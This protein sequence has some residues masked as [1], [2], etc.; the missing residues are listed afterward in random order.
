VRFVASAG[1]A[2]GVKTR[3][4]R[5]GLNAKSV[6]NREEAKTRAEA[7]RPIFVE[8]AGKPANAIAAELNKRAVAT[9]R[10]GRWHAETVLRVQRRLE[11]AS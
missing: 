2:E 5:G 9:P 4:V 1:G 11:A 3:G 7:L 10:G 6:Q 8:L